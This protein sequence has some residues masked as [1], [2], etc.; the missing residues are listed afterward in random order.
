MSEE[1]QKPEQQE[2]KISEK[3]RAKYYRSIYLIQSDSDLKIL[4]AYESKN[5]A[6]SDIAYRGNG[7]HIKEIM[8]TKKNIFPQKGTKPEQQVKKLIKF[9]TKYHNF[10][11]TIIINKERDRV[12]CYFKCG[13]KNK[14]KDVYKVRAIM[15]CKD[16]DVFDMDW[17]IRMAKKK[18]YM[19]LAE[20]L[21]NYSKRIESEQKK[22]FIKA[23]IDYEDLL[24]KKYPITQ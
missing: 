24:Y 23:K 6:I 8:A 21:F 13:N 20:K 14:P 11:C 10:P 12:I 18:A 17:G 15:Y 22:K 19:K 3:E 16:G 7:Y 9:E 4:E 1:N 5:D 2:G